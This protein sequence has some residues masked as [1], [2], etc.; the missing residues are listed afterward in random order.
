MPR[1]IA[2]RRH[3]GDTRYRRPP[4]QEPSH[5]TN[6][7]YIGSFGLRRTWE[8]YIYCKTSELMLCVESVSPFAKVMARRTDQ[9][10]ADYFGSKNSF[11]NP[12]KVANFRGQV[13]VGEVLDKPPQVALFVPRPAAVVSTATKLT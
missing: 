3:H 4:A 2:Q 10:V 8:F 12:T 9:E 11:E 7:V 1:M 13:L 5:P 6:P